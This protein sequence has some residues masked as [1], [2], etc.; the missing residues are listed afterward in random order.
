MRHLSL[1]SLSLRLSFT[2]THSFVGPTTLKLNS[3]YTVQLKTANT[4]LVWRCADEVSW[5]ATAHTD[6]ADI[7]SIPEHFIPTVPFTPALSI[8]LR[9][10]NSWFRIQSK[11]LVS[12]GIPFSG[13]QGECFV[14]VDK[15]FK[16]LATF[17][18][19]FSWITNM[20]VSSP[21]STSSPTST[22]R[23]YNLKVDVLQNVNNRNDRDAVALIARWNSNGG[24][25]F[26]RKNYLVDQTHALFISNCLPSSTSLGR[27][28][29]VVVVA[30]WN[31]NVWV[32]KPEGLLNFN[33]MDTIFLLLMN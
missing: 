32:K 26:S 31:S 12:I 5:R 16:F 25:R 28:W 8:H 10:F 19:W 6:Y 3:L 4:I 20:N 14:L 17:F 27:E 15:I 24:P 7:F 29:V 21:W 22:K 13:W 9:Y 18:A 2:L 1:L 11:F 30:R 33:K 23:P